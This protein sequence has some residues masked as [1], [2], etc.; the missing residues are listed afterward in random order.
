MADYIDRQAAIAALRKFAEECNGSTEA[1]TAAAMAISVISRMPGAWVELTAN[2]QPEYPGEYIVCCD[3]ADCKP[4]WGVWYE[5]NVVVV[6]EYD[7]EGVDDS[8]WSWDEHGTEYA[9]GDLITHWM[10]KPDAPEGKKC[11]C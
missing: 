11:E 3:D 5:K 9:I 7:P 2:T 6:A 10:K 1:A 4:G 8:E